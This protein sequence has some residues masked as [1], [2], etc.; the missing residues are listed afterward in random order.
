VLTHTLYGARLGRRFAFHPELE[1]STA[2]EV[3]RA[4]QPARI[5]VARMVNDDLRHVGKGV[6][7]LAEVV[8]EDT[9]VSLIRSSSL[10]TEPRRSWAEPTALAKLRKMR[11]MKRLLDLK[12]KKCRWPV[13]L[14]GPNSGLF[15]GKPTP[16]FGLPYAKST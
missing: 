4:T 7:Y 3:V 2:H 12:A 13:P 14:A 1:V 16:R 9:K 15:C 8:H 11:V 10:C 6:P 5:T